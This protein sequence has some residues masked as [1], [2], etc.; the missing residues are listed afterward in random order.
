[1][2][3]RERRIMEILKL[4]NGRENPTW[5]DETEKYYLEKELAE[6]RAKGGHRYDELDED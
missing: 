3:D 4:I 6:I 1:M 2:T 5:E